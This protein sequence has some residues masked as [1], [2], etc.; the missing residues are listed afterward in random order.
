MLEKTFKKVFFI[1]KI[2][3]LKEGVFVAKT[4][5]EFVNNL[6]KSRFAKKIIVIFAN[7]ENNMNEFLNINQKLL[8]RFSKK[9]IF[10]N[11]KSK[12]C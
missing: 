12:D 9:I 10:I 3:R 4:I 7:Y 1:D 11:I 5:N 6:T 2:Y 8:N